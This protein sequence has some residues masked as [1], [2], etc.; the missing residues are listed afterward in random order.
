MLEKGVIAFDSKELNS[1]AIF[2]GVSSGAKRGPTY[3]TE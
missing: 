2:S 1:V 3:H